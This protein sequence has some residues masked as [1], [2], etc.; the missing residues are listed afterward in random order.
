MKD[1]ITTFPGVEGIAEDEISSKWPSVKLGGIL[2]SKNNSLVFFES[3]DDGINFLNIKTAEDL[4][5]FLGEVKL[6][7]HINDLK[8]IKK[9]IR[10]AKNFELALALHR[11]IYKKNFKVATFR[12]VAQSNSDYKNYRRVDAQKVAESGINER[13]NHR[14]RI[15]E[16]D[17]HIEIWLHLLNR[18]PRSSAPG[19]HPEPMVYWN[20][21]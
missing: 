6:F 5:V 2:K 21:G 11:R 14:W 12:V 7:N 3:K 4:Y 20:H 8:E 13:Y 16:D 18:I 17:S 19:L 9:T 10:E 1:Y 15:V